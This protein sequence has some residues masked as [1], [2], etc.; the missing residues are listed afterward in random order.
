MNNQTVIQSEA[1]I[2][3][4]IFVCFHLSFVSYNQYFYL[5]KNKNKKGTR[6]IVD[7]GHISCEHHL[8]IIAGIEM[9]SL[10]RKSNADIQNTLV[11]GLG[12]GGLCSFVAN[13][14]K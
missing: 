2:K 14:I 4:G 9:M 12:G 11:V 3:I 5:V 7:L 6:K 13:Y 8:Y 1:L 10:I